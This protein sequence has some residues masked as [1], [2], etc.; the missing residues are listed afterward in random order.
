MA[1]VRFYVATSLDGFIADREG[2]VDWLAPYDA[3]LYGYDKFIS[4]V[5]ALIMGRRTYELIFAIGEDW[6]YAGKPVYVL[7][8]SSLGDVPQGVVT[9]T[10]GIKAALQ[11][12]RE[13]TRNDIWIV[14]GAVTMQSALEEGLVDMVEIFL[15]PVLLGSGLSLLNDLSRRPTL[16]F[17]GIEA[18]PDG[19]VK[20]R[21]LVPG[22]SG[23]LR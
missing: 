8:S 6:P 21:Y 15:V 14:G 19:V 1:R 23:V 20:L 7:S 2:S 9:N 18:F 13:T 16:V 4:E 3:R 11:Q 5:G 10:R 12:A 22:R 17:D